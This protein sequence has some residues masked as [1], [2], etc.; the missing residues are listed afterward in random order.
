MTHK[1]TI[2]LPKKL[3]MNISLLSEELG[4]S[5]SEMI[6]PSILKYVVSSNNLKS[7]NGFSFNK[8]EIVRRTVNVN[9]TVHRVLNVR[10]KE[11]GVSVNTMMVFIIQKTYI[12]YA[13]ILRDIREIE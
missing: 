6:R 13:N 7:I 2:R 12:Y 3:A 8:D 10:S 9:D 11:Y 1:L 5:N 4:L